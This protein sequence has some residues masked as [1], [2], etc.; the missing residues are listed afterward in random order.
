MKHKKWKEI[1]QGIK[2]NGLT[3]GFIIIV[4]DVL[5]YGAVLFQYVYSG[6][7]C[8]ELYIFS[9]AFFKI[10]ILIGSGLIGISLF[11]RMLN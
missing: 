9:I 6:Y 7:S 1:I 8:T 3:Y 2:Q 11:L 4:I 10:C 5:A